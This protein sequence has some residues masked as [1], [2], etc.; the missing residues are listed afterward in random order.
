MYRVGKL[1][2]Y[3]FLS[4]RG[5]IRLKVLNG[6]SDFLRRLNY[7]FGR[8]VRFDVDEIGVFVGDVEQGGE[9]RLGGEVLELEC[10][11]LADQETH[12]EVA[13]SPDFL[14]RKNKSYSLSI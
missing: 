2:P 6:D 5:G 7:K 4:C 1:S 13:K 8:K 14:K 11:R 10:G 12:R 3:L 9:R